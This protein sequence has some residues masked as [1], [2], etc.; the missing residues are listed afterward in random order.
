M[1][2]GAHPNIEPAGYYDVPPDLDTCANDGCTRSCD[3]AI[4]LC[5]PC[6]SD[7]EEDAKGDGWR[8]E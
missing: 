6:L 4:G 5:E 8:D 2:F 3:P 1:S 7:A